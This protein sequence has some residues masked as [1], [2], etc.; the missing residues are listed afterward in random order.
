MQSITVFSRLYRSREYFLGGGAPNVP[1]FGGSL[2]FSHVNDCTG[3]TPRAT[4]RY[5][6]QDQALSPVASWLSSPGVTTKS[7]PLPLCQVQ[8]LSSHL[9]PYFRIYTLLIRR[10]LQLTLTSPGFLMLILEPSVQ[11]PLDCQRKKRHQEAGTQPLMT[12]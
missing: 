11:A 7:A 5:Q 3:C 6:D 1:G 12:R 9:T 8:H 2:M 4:K 10:C